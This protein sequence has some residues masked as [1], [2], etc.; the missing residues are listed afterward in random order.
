MV[1]IAII[2]TSYMDTIN[3]IINICEINSM[4][5][6]DDDV[7]CLHT[8]CGAWGWYTISYKSGKRDLL[9]HMWRLNACEAFTFRDQAS[10]FTQSDWDKSKQVEEKLE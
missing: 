1:L 10:A 6:F 8:L 9:T 3:I 4:L 2:V 7:S 5:C